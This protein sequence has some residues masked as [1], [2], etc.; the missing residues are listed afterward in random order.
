MEEGCCRRRSY[1]G[2]GES[3]LSTL[4]LNSVQDC[5]KG[6]LGKAAV[7]P[8]LLIILVSRTQ[9]LGAIV[10]GITEGF[11]YA[12][13]GVSPSHENLHSIE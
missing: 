13:E 12:S 6:R 4:F 9:S 10:E 2:K 5:T 7:E 8:G 3:D 11:M 1:T